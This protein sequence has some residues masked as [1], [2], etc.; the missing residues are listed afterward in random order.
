MSGTGLPQPLA[1]RLRSIWGS[2]GLERFLADPYGAILHM[3]GL[4]FVL[5]DAAALRSGADPTD[6]RRIEAGIQHV[7]WRAARDMGHVNV[8]S[9]DLLRAAASL[10]F[11]EIQLDEAGDPL[12]LCRQGLERLIAAGAVVAEAGLV[13][14][15]ELYD[16]ECELAEHLERLVRARSRHPVSLDE[17]AVTLAHTRFAQLGADQLR[18]VHAGLT[19]P[20]SILTG[21]PGTG[22]TTAIAALCTCARILAPATEIVLAAPTGRASRRL[23]ELT[24]HPA[25]T[26]HRLL[27]MVPE[28]SEGLEPLF[29]RDEDYP[30][31]GDLLIVDEASMLDLPLAAGLFRAVPPGMRVVLVG[32]VDQLP[33]VGPGDVLRDFIAAGLPSIRLEHIFRQRD[34]SAIVR[35]ARQVAAGQ[36]PEPDPDHGFDWLQCTSAAMAA[37]MAVEA[38]AQAVNHGLDITGVQVLSPMRRGQAGVDALNRRLQSRLNDVDGPV[39][40]YGG[41]EFRSGD[42]IMCTRNNYAKGPDGI[43]NGQVGV[44]R[45][46]DPEINALVAEFDGW[47]ITFAGDELADLQPAYCI[48]VHKSQGSEFDTVILCLVN[49][50]WPMLRRNLLYT[51]VTRAQ[52]QLLLV[53][54]RRAL[55]RAVAQATVQLRNTGLR[56]RIAHLA[57][58]LP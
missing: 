58:L 49:E 44:V 8:S 7:L 50:H 9:H 42:K 30:L 46:V 32:D 40:K 18:A 36:I 4:D 22:K 48:T 11:R 51:A 43:F 33:P 16:A 47:D 26:I 52:K 53:G 35:V 15:T 54:D 13:Y 21:G 25:M 1:A 2:G 45:E 12:W 3:P 27:E 5:A 10:L 23:A 31:R 38:A 55:Q 20:V 41:Q 28:S 29:R 17:V 19:E 57:D 6:P 14:L 34:T 56:Q 37:E 39:V 24:G